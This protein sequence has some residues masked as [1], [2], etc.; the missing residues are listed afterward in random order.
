MA[1]HGIHAVEAIISTSTNTTT[2]TTNTNTNTKR[3]YQPQSAAAAGRVDW[4]GGHIGH[5]RSEDHCTIQLHCP[6]RGGPQRYHCH[7]LAQ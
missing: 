2:T 6:K 7:G 4:D 5:S 1:H 3:Q